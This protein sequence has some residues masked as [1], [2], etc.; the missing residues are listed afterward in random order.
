MARPA[1]P[2]KEK[3]LRGAIP[4]TESGCWLWGNGV[5]HRGYGKTSMGRKTIAA[6]RAAYEAFVGSIPDGMSVLHRCDVPSCVNPDHLFLGSQADNIK[7]KV[8]KKRQAS[9]E[10]HGMSKLS[11]DAAR[12]I[13]FGAA[14]ARQAADEHGVSAC[15]VRQIRSGLYWKHLSK[16]GRV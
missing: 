7:D 4:V 6:H 13:K 14:S 8:A 9:G 16:G 5:N 15:M 3:I 10:R 1:I 12:A 11:E 2:M